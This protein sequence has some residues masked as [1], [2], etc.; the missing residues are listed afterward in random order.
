VLL[1]RGDASWA[2]DWERDG[3]LDAFRTAEL[4]TITNAGHWVHHDQ[5]G[6]FLRVVRQFLKL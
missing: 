2:G 4:V 1:V 3:R 6:E 5:L